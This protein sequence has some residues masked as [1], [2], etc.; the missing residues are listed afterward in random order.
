MRRPTKTE[1]IQIRVTRAEKRD[2]VQRARAAGLDLSSWMLGRLS[3]PHAVTFRELVRSL[4]AAPDPSYVFAEIGELL[5]GLRRDQ[6]SA[7]VEVLPPV[8]LGALPANLLAAMVELRAT[9]L[10]V[11]PPIWTQ[12]IQPLPQ[13]WFPTALVSVRLE[14]LCNS[15]PAFRRRNL[16]VTSTLEHRA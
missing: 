7:A 9:R 10:G 2:L 13:P 12:Q 8:Q 15:P 6:W 4:A 3:P 14:L 16:F 11:R 1:Q 5:S